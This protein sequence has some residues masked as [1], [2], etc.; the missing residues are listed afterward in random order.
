MIYGN[1]TSID[2]IVLAKSG[3][4]SDHL[5]RVERLKALQKQAGWSDSD[6]AR[7]CGRS[8]QQVWAWYSNSRLI[9][10]RLARALEARLGLARFALDDRPGATSQISTANVAR[11]EGLHLASDAKKH[12]RKVPVLC[13]TDLAKMLDTDNAT[14][15]QTR[16][17]LET[18]AVASGRA[19]FL[20]MLDDS[21]VPAIRVDDHLLLDPTE[22]P[23]AGDIVLVRVRTGEY[24]VRVFR[25]RTAFVFEAAPLNPAYQA[26]SS[27]TDA[28]EVVAVMVELRSYRRSN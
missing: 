10:E 11:F 2:A 5:V 3:A 9:G 25:P 23:R 27:D 21:M 24:F 17:H 14:L 6:L 4:M 26:L 16:P 7:Q 13:W 20:L 1:L 28:A 15:R 8:P 19:K 12:A 22:S 18:F